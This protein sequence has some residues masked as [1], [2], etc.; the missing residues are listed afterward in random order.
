MFGNCLY[1][2]MLKQEPKP[3]PADIVDKGCS[4]WRKKDKNNHPLLVDII[5]KFEGRILL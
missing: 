2:R 1:F 3:I 5:K 4:N